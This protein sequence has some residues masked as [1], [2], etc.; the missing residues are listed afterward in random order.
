[1]PLTRQHCSENAG[2][3]STRTRAPADWEDVRYGVEYRKEDDGLL[4][5]PRNKAWHGTCSAYLTSGRIQ[6]SDRGPADPHDALHVLPSLPLAR[7]TRRD[8]HEWENRVD[9]SICALP[10]PVYTLILA[11]SRL[12][13]VCRLWVIGM[14]SP[15]PQHYYYYPTLSSP[16]PLN[17]HHSSLDAVRG[18]HGQRQCL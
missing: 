7:S 13:H 6:A 18:S 14:T 15:S 10:A 1:M 17:A 3:G 2:R 11:R 16:C 5:G 12:C 8:G 9:R 4:S